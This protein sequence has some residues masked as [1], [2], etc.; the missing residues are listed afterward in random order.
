MT[1]TEAHCSPRLLA[2]LSHKLLQ[3]LGMDFSGTRRVD[4]LRR[5]QLLA[6]E[7]EVDDFDGWLQDLAFAEWDAAKV[8]S[9]ISAFT[10]GET[11]FRRDAE[12][13]DW[14]AS[15]HLPALLARRRAAGRRH[16]RLWSAGCCTG[17]EA[18]GLLFLIDEL[19]AGEGADWSVELVAS[20][21]NAGFLARAEQGVYGRNAFRSSEAHFRDR[22]FQA[23]GRQ[24]RVRPA[25]RGRI[26]FVQY[27]LADSRLP[28]ALAEADLILCRNVLMYLSPDR[29]LAA[30]R[31]LLASL[32]ADGALLLS[33]VEAGLAT[34]AGLSGR[35]AGCNY[36]LLAAGAV[37][38]GPAAPP[39]PVC[40]PPQPAP[41]PRP[42][43]WWRV[44][45]PA[46]AAEPPARD[47]AAHESGLPEHYWRQFAQARARGA[48]GQAREALSGYLGCTGLGREQQHRACL[49]MAR[50]WADQQRLEQAR[51]WLRRALQLDGAAPAAYWLQAL[52]AQQEGDNRAALLAL[53]RALYLDPGFIL[54]YFLRA[55]LLRAEGQ[56]RASDKTLRVCR[57]LLLDQDG[58]ALVPH[59]DGIDCAQ[60]LRLCDQLQQGGR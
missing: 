55:R 50:S 3:H 57:Q 56:G 7:H 33:A 60:L 28:P 46:P 32:S 39:A 25:W 45:T 59:G 51:E 11:Y 1:R 42:V 18:Y 5:L 58:D 22:H 30:L 26:R 14:L 27:N 37:G 54:G 10:V 13:F 48:H 24:W 6:R 53:Q 16:L 15:E 47:A 4:L 12:A 21:I 31:R 35:W 38:L 20:D 9:L 29:A 2:T 41:L 40:L 34:Q 43:E 17:E 8:Q 23:E 52:L 44:P 49:A 36:A 19:L